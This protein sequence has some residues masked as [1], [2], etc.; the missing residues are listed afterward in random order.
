MMKKCLVLGANGFIGSSLVEELLLQGHYVRAF[1]RYT[2]D[3]VIFHQEEGD[4]LEFVKGDFLNQ[5]EVKEALKD[6]DYVFHFIWLSNPST[7]AKSA[8][9]EIDLNVKYTLTLLDACVD[10][11]IEKVIFAS[12]GGT[13]Y[14]NTPDLTRSKEADPTLPISP[15]GI[16]KLTIENFLRYYHIS[17]GLDYVTFRI[18]N[19]YGRRQQTNKKQGIFAIFKELI[20]N[21]K[22]INVFGDGSNVRDYIEVD[23][24]VRIMVD[25]SFKEALPE[26]L[27]NVGSGEGKSILEV[28]KQIEEELNKKALVTFSPG[29]KFDVNYNVLSTDLIKLRSDIVI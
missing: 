6:I 24:A 13:V 10:H 18:A 28:I 12:S 2:A 7:T 19:P 4:N 17:F 25:L 3:Q 9:S 29:R 22:P 16:A 1:D 15:Y 27:F 14:G 21:D 23:H 20:L 8:Y 11:N 5:G 26:K